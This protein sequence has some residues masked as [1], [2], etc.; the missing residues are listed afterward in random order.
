LVPPKIGVHINYIKVLPEFRATN[1]K[2]QKPKS[3]KLDLAKLLAMDSRTAAAAGHRGR[4]R[5]NTRRCSNRVDI[6]TV[7]YA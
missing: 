7:I 6:P 2:G 4:H 5:L 1:A 3:K